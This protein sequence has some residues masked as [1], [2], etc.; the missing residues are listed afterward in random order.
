[1][2]LSDC[3]FCEGLDFDAAR[4]SDSPDTKRPGHAA[5]RQRYD[6]TFSRRRDGKI[7]FRNIKSTLYPYPSDPVWLEQQTELFDT[8]TS[9]TYLSSVVKKLKIDRDDVIAW[10][11]HRTAPHNLTFQISVLVKKKFSDPTPREAEF[12]AY[13]DTVYAETERRKKKIRKAYLDISDPRDFEDYV[14]KEHYSIS[15]LFGVALVKGHVGM[16]SLYRPPRQYDTSDRLLVTVHHLDHLLVHLITEFRQ[17]L[18]DDVRVPL[19]I[20][21]RESKRMLQASTRITTAVSALFD[22]KKCEV[23]LEPMYRIRHATASTRITF[24][25]LQYAKLFTETLDR[26]ISPASLDVEALLR[27]LIGLNLNSRGFLNTC[28]DWLQERIGETSDSIEAIHLV[29]GWKKNIRQILSMQTPYRPDLPSTKDYLLEWLDAELEHREKVS[30]LEILPAPS[31]NQHASPKLK[32]GVS[33]GK[34]ALLF[35]LLGDARVLVAES[36]THLFRFIAANF[37]TQNGA[38]ISLRS[39]STRCY[40]PENSAIEGVSAVLDDMREQLKNR[41]QPR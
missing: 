29:L 3:L 12:L 24:Q 9:E 36:K 32:L 1:M 34:L 33:V 14:R 11:I 19:T 22:E 37:R 6:V 16:D 26:L 17:Y 41:Q 38:N 31:M 20:L 40:Q 21:H 30:P 10:T 25:Q 27:T 2:Y 35:S 39:V 7:T 13:V 23:L 8:G 28:V 15:R 18:S 5:L 4:K